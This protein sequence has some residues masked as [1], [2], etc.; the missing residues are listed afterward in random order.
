MTKSWVLPDSRENAESWIKNLVVVTWLLTFFFCDNL[1][2]AIKKRLQKLKIV[3]GKYCCSYITFVKTDLFSVDSFFSMKGLYENYQSMPNHF[4]CKTIIFGV[5][6]IEYVL[7][8][9]NFSMRVP[10]LSVG[11]ISAPNWC[12]VNVCQLWMFPVGTLILF[13]KNEFI[14]ICFIFHRFF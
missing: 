9:R 1:L 13:Y 4:F 7:L 5:I 10:A 2:T 14:T 8:Y 3:N 6:Q 11:Y 12:I